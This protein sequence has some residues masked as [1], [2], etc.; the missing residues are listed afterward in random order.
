MIRVNN[1]LAIVFAAVLLLAGCAGVRN[2]YES[3]LDAGTAADKP[4]MTLKVGERSEILAI[5]DGFPGWWGYYPG[6][7]SLNS[8]VATITC[9]AGRGFIP[10]REPGVIFGGET[11]YIEALKVGV[12]WLLKGNRHTFYNVLKNTDL[13]KFS[14]GESFPPR[15]KHVEMLIKVKTV[16]ASE[17]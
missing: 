9:E 4:V 17:R 2:S 7:V 12:A 5:G 6:F 13:S 1:F 8:D 14:A 10:F 3:M 15:P 11:C 16:P